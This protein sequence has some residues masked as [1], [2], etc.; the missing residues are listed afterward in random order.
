ML[1]KGALERQEDG[2]A[3]LYST[4]LQAP[5]VQRSLLG[6]LKD[7]AFG[8]S[9]MDLVLQALGHSD[10]TEDELEQLEQLIAQKKKQRKHG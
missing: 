4:P 8:G 1:D 7:K 10:P 2:R 3:H 6:R 5:K 9:A